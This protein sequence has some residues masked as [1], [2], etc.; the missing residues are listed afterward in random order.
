MLASRTVSPSFVLRRRSWA[1]LRA[2]RLHPIFTSRYKARPK[3]RR[4]LCKVISLSEQAQTMTSLVMQQKPDFL[5]RVPPP[6]TKNL[7]DN[8]LK[9]HDKSGRSLALQRDFRLA[10]IYAERALQFDN[11]IA[12]T[13]E[14]KANSASDLK[15]LGF[16]TI[17]C[18]ER[19]FC[20]P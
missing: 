20:V 18:T 6:T 1:A 11:R 2:M 4:D 16:I 15:S 14:R 5:G 9:T 19:R 13:G 8:K 17:C 3:P 7:Y 10:K 12:L